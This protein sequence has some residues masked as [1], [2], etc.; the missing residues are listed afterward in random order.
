MKLFGWLKGPL[1]RRDKA[2][3]F[4][5]RAM[6]HAKLHDHKAALADY[7]AVIDM[8][9]APADVRAMALYNRS[10][11]HTASHDDPQAVGDLEKLLEM[12]GAA[13]NVKTEAKRKL[14]RVRRTSDR[15]EERPS[16]PGF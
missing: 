1:S 14:V 15:A 2:M 11:V 7:T 8:A 10:V 6:A 16:T 9:D 3:S 13:E 12:E 5:K 4:Y